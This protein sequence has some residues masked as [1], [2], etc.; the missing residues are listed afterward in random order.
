MRSSA[1]T[2]Q[3]FFWGALCAGLYVGAAGRDPFADYE[4]HARIAQLFFE[5]REVPAHPLYHILSIIISKLTALSL[6]FSGLGIVG[7]ASL[8][9]FFICNSY[10]ASQAEEL[11][12][13]VRSISVIA[14]LFFHA[15]PILFFYD[16]HLYLGYVTPLVFHNPTILIAKVV[17]VVYF[18][19]SLELFKK[20]SIR[21]LDFVLFLLLSI[22]SALAKPSFL[23]TFVPAFGMVLLLECYLSKKIRKKLIGIYLISMVVPVIIIFLWQ[24]EKL[25]GGFVGPNQSEIKISAFELFKLTS[26]TWTLFPKMILSLLFP[27]WMIFSNLDWVRID[28]VIQLS[29]FNLVLALFLNYFVSETGPRFSHGNFTWSAQLA[30]FIL[31]LVCVGKLLE[32]INKNMGSRWGIGIQVGV[33]GLFLHV[34]SGLWWLVSNLELIPF[35]P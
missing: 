18:C 24:S 26:S 29:V 4:G 12:S 2:T 9:L 30:L 31:N 11:S 33:T 35:T 14:L 27:I 32:K 1:L 16:H 19:L 15:I 25:F 6:K 28:R 20:E 8:S 5:T 34:V 3:T 22:L 7:I 10:L 21:F 23:V 17:G 13:S